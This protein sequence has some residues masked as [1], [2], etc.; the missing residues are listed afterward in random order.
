SLERGK[1]TLDDPLVRP[2]AIGVGQRRG[3]D[4]HSDSADDDQLLAALA[5]GVIGRSLEDSGHC[6]LRIADSPAAARM[7][8]RKQLR[9]GL[10]SPLEQ[11][12]RDADHDG[13]EKDEVKQ[14]GPD[15]RKSSLF[16]QQRL[17]AVYG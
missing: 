10:E 9:L 2:V 11:R 3:H 14:V 7:A 1:E 17:E 13:G 4:Q 6:E 8:I 16:Q 12:S 5:A 15:G